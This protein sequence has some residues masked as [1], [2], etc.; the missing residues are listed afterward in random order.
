MEHSIRAD[1]RAPKPKDSLPAQQ[2]NL[3]PTHRAN[4][5]LAHQRKPQ[6]PSP[7]N[8]GWPKKQTKLLYHIPQANIAYSRLGLHRTPGL[9][10]I[11]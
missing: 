7:L 5:K 1:Y 8:Q 6:A 2:P 11:N 4:S 9:V 3:A 10:H